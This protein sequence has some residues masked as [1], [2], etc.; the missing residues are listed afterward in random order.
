MTRGK[1]GGCG[2]QLFQQEHERYGDRE[3]LLSSR[4]GSS[5]LRTCGR[6]R[7]K[8][9]KTKALAYMCRVSNIHIYEI[10]SRIIE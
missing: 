9:S 6:R 2:S 8:A 7:F 3:M 5:I 10:A 4:E 1:G